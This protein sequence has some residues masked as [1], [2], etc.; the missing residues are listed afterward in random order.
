MTA[1]QRKTI[2][3]LSKGL[4]MDKDELHVLVNCLTGCASLAELTDKQADSVIYDLRERMKYSNR[5][6]PMDNRK[7]KSGVQTEAGMMTASQQKKAWALMFRLRELDDAPRYHEDGKP[8]TVG[9]RMAGAI[10]KI[11]GNNIAKA[12]KDIFAR[13]SFEDGEKLIEGLKRYVRTAERKKERRTG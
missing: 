11:T 8:F 13:V 2:F 7:P 12:G 6:E 5:T 10:E 9:E 4:N 3:G 1:M